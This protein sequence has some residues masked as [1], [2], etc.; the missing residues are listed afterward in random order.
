[1]KTVEIGLITP[2][3]GLNIYVLSSVTKIP[4]GDAFRRVTPFVLTD[5]V[6]L[7][8]LVAIPEITLWLPK[9]ALGA[10]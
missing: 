7:T 2:P 1:M 9:L 5:M 10:P 3:L 6:L 8:V 4:I